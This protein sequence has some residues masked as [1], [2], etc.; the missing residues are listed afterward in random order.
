MHKFIF[1]PPKYH[2]RSIRLKEYD[3]SQA[4]AHFIT[5]V[6][7]QRECLFGEV[8]NGEMILNVFGEIVRVEL[9]RTSE[10]RRGLN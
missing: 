9:E 8:I 3:Y 2:R 1:D 6:R 10:I 5:S 4:G 7:Y